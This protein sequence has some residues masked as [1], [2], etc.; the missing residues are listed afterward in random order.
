MWRGSSAYV[1]GGKSEEVRLYLAQTDSVDV[2]RFL[3]I[4]HPWSMYRDW[5]MLAKGGQYEKVPRT[6]TG[7]Q[8]M[9]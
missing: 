1:T 8:F 2:E 4:S 3:Y 7:V 5:T 6:I 9:L